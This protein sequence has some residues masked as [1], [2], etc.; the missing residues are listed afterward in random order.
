MTLL[1][2]LMVF[3]MYWSVDSSIK[4]GVTTSCDGV[5]NVL[6]SRWQNK[7][8]DDNFLFH[9]LVWLVVDW[10]CLYRSINQSDFISWTSETYTLQST[11]V[12]PWHKIG[13][14]KWELFWKANCRVSDICLLKKSDLL[15][16]I[17]EFAISLT[18]LQK[19]DRELCCLISSLRSWLGKPNRPIMSQ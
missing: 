16:R 2:R 14:C 3:L 5:F 1:H 8:R 9:L 15:D 19:A 7:V 6:I 11:V 10:L 13:T 4:Y 17:I 18:I 12:A